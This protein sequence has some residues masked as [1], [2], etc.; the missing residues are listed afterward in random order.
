MKTQTREYCSGT[1][2]EGKERLDGKTV[3]ITG[4]TDGIG[5]ET[6][7]DLAKRG[8]RIFM[9]SRDDQK[10]EEVRKSVVLETANKYIYCRSC[11]LASQESIRK[12][13]DRFNSGNL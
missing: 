2:Y 9:A 10:C 13:A 11:D 3:V 12:F 7:R 4:G 5:K 8:A 1:K 6:V